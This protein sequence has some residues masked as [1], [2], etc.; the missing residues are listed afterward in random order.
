MKH[1]GDYVLSKESFPKLE[2]VWKEW[3]KPAFQ[4]LTEQK[5]FGQVCRTLL[6]LIESAPEGSFLLIPVLDFV[7]KINQDKILEHFHFNNFELWLNQFSGLGSEENRYIRGKIAG[8][9]V[10]RDAY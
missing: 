8:R 7:E 6:K 10:P 5:K 9:W 1:L 2:I 3:K 4:K